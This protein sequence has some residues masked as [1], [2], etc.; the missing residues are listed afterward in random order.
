MQ[1]LD[2]ATAGVPGLMTRE[3]AQRRIDRVADAAPELNIL[4]FVYERHTDARFVPVAILGPSTLW[5]ATMLANAG[6][7][8]TNGR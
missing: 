1:T 4:V 7:F 2:D 3:G 6:I 8:V 5:A